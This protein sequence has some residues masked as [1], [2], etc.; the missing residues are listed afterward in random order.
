[1]GWE[2]YTRLMTDRARAPWHLWVMGLI[3]LALYLIAA[4]DYVSTLIMDPGYFAELGYGPEQ[5]AYF[6]DYP[7]LPRIVWAVNVVGGI[8]AG[9]LLLLRSR[10]C[11]PIA[12]VAALALSIMLIVTFGFMGRWQA[13]GPALSIPDI[14][15]WAF[16]VGFWL[17]SRA[18]R[19][20][21]VLR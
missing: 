10:W 12:L 2:K 5:I 8:L 9:V 20:R 3:I 13:L 17:Y 15:V 11:S 6:T 16:T 21:G 4:R 18:M 14:L 7:I 19:S 1:M